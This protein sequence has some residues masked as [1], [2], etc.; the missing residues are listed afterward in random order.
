[1]KS[2]RKGVTTE[3]LFLPILSLLKSFVT[4]DH[5]VP[6]QRW[7]H[8]NLSNDAQSL[9]DETL[10]IYHSKI[11]KLLNFPHCCEIHSRVLVIVFG[12]P[13]M[14][15]INCN[16]EACVQECFCWLFWEAFKP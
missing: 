3:L 7:S 5:I 10:T 8:G 15:L 9:H 16:P 13:L 2:Q 12:L 11:D 6:R 1:M 14:R 4:G